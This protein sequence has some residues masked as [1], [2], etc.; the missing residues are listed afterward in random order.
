[1]NEIAPKVLSDEEWIQQKV[2]R[3]TTHRHSFSVMDE[4]PT[5]LVIHLFTLLEKQDGN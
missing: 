1:M 4:S 5:N 2:N 3:D